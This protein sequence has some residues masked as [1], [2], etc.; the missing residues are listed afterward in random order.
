MNTLRK[1]ILVGLAALS[2]GAAAVGVHAQAQAPEARHGHA[3]S[4]EQRQ[5][6]MDEF[7]AKR[8]AK[9]HDELKLTSAQEPAWTAF[10]N[11]IKPA[12][13]AGRPDRAAW[14]G[15]TAPARME[16]M[17]ALSKERTARMEQHLQALNKFYATLTPEQKKVFD[18]H[19]LHAMGE[20]GWDH[21][22]HG[23]HGMHHQGDKQG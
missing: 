5:A 1:Q 14:A 23:G 17:I 12:P 19:T 2:M 3:T 15:M 18:Q 4:P 22:G 16:K 9:L 6:K 21:G 11:A 20:R 13:L 8:Q 7:M 10:V